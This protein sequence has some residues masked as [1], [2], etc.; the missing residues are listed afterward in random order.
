MDGGG[1]EAVVLRYFRHVDRE[2]V[3]FDFIVDEGSTHV[4]EAEIEALGG[5]VFIVPP[6][7]KLAAHVKALKSLCRA[8]SWQVVHSHRNALSVIPLAVARAERVPIRI[9]HSH[10]T[11]G[12]DETLR[13]A[14]KTVLK[15]TSRIMPTERFAC[16]EFA[17]RW[18]FGDASFTVL[19]NAF[20]LDKFTFSPGFRKSWRAELDLSPDTLVFGHVGRFMSQKD[21]DCLVRAFAEVLP[22]RRNTALVLVGSGPLE[23]HIRRLAS[24]LGIAGNVRFLGH[25]ADVHELYSAF[26]CFVLPS[27]YEGLCV[28]ALEAQANGL[29]SILSDAVTRE[30]VLSERVNFVPQGSV[31]ELARA[32]AS[33]SPVESRERPKL[34]E[35]YNIDI[36]AADLT[37][38]YMTMV[39]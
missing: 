10:S 29:P 22:R 14:V 25:R 17:G 15:T 28:A 2:N 18:L 7:G 12:G 38:W 13:N 3:V 20:E 39:S 24:D 8:H 26:D 6:I 21:H 16:G 19:P 31:A 23:A 9:A 35:P 34:L 11:A 1:V 27:K 36:A 37:R 30:L 5:R 33:F 4:P 32:M